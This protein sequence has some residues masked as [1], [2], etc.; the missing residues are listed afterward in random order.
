MKLVEIF[1]LE[2]RTCP[3]IPRAIRD[4][5]RGQVQLRQ[6][7]AGG[8]LRPREAEQ[9]CGAEGCAHVANE[10]LLLGVLVADPDNERL[11]VHHVACLQSDGQRTL[12]VLRSNAVGGEQPVQPFGLQPLPLGVGL[13]RLGA[14][15]GGRVR[16]A[17]A[18]GRVVVGAGA[19]VGQLLGQRREDE[20][21]LRAVRGVR[22]PREGVR[23]GVLAHLVQHRVE[24]KLVRANE[25]RD[26]LHDGHHLLGVRGQRVHPASDTEAEEGAAPRRQQR[27]VDLHGLRRAMA[28]DDALRVLV[29]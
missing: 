13:G 10:R 2:F 23:D 3:R 5:R 27:R 1:I 26:V 16:G 20:Y 29:A 4:T 18:V 28:V 19:G 12:G 24:G 14:A 11:G 6:A 17:A 7:L 21:N 9:P 22:G 8:V 15:A 25:L